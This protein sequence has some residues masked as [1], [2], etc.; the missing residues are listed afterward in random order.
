MNSGKYNRNSPNVP[1]RTITKIRIADDM[2]RIASQRASHQDEK[3]HSGLG[4]E[5]D[6]KGCLGEVIAEYWMEKVGIEYK[7]ELDSKKNDYRLKNS[8]YT[9]DVKTKDRNV[10]PARSYDCT[11][12]FYNHTYQDSHFFLFVS[13]QSFKDCNDLDLVDKFEFAFIVGSVTYEE[14]KNI[15]ISYLHDEQDWTNGTV[16]WTTALNVQMYQLIS[17]IDTIRLFKSDRKTLSQLIECIEKNEATLIPPVN[18][19]RNLIEIMHS[20]ISSG[21]LLDRPFPPW[22][23]EKHTAL[24]ALGKKIIEKKEFNPLDRAVVELRLKNLNLDLV[25]NKGDK[26]NFIAELKKNG[27]ELH[28]RALPD[29]LKRYKLFWPSHLN[30]YRNSSMEI[31]QILRAGL[32]QKLYIRKR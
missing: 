11:V 15:G 31:E 1:D 21:Q 20:K 24:K 10:E 2:R 30:K 18:I 14:L 25:K 13:L 27:H 6:F 8:G 12:P 26:N 23:D 28:W 19:N 22:T 32:T 5:A 4:S 17:V 16:M 3:D 29:L 9:F 7:S